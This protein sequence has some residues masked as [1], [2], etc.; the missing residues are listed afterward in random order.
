MTAI[1]DALPRAFRAIVPRPEDRIP[2]TP[3][4][5]IHAGLAS[6]PLV[7]LAYLARRP[8]TYVLRLL[9]LPIAVLPLIHVSFGNVWTIPSL[10]VYNW[11]QSYR[12]GLLVEV[13][14]AKAL[15][16]ALTKQGMLKHD[17]KT[18]HPDTRASESLRSALA[19]LCTTRGLSFKFSGG[20]HGPPPKRPQERFGMVFD[21]ITFIAVL[22]FNTPASAWPPVMDNPW[23]A[24]SLHELWSLRWHQLLRR[25]FYVFGGIP[26]FYLAGPFGMLFGTFLASGL[27]HETS[28]YAMGKGLDPH[29]VLFF[30]IQAPLMVGERMWRQVTGRRVGGALGRA[31]VYFVIFVVA[32]PMVDSWH[33][34]GLGGGMVIPPFLSPAR[35]VVLPLLQHTSSRTIDSLGNIIGSGNNSRTM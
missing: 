19:L 13:L 15:E 11:G 25:T 17:E 1:Y 4:T 7:L 24:N 29:P 12:T 28:I 27:F 31:W 22:V 9:V 3:L 32:Q 5:G 23:V 34:R 30:A 21:L 8:Q 18:L 20:T 6:L 26:G 16:I 10:N 35:L 33:R 2:V 14:V